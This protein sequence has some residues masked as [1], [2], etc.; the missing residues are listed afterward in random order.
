MTN[1]GRLFTATL[2]FTGNVTS[3]QF[4]CVLTAL[5]APQSVVNLPSSVEAGDPPKSAGWGDFTYTI[6]YPKLFANSTESI[7]YSG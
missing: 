7:A 5:N 1:S 3:Q 2:G 6:D 4:D